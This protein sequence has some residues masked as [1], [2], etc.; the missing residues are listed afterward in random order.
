MPRR[1][2]AHIAR[3]DQ[4]VLLQAPDQPRQRALAQVHGRPRSCMRQLVRRLGRREPLEHLELAEPEAVLALQRLVRARRDRGVAGEHLTPVAT[5][6]G[7]RI[8]GHGGALYRDWQHIA[9]QSLHVH[10]M[11]MHVLYVGMTPLPSPSRHVRRALGP[12]AWA[13]AGAAVRRAVPRRARRLD[14]RR[15]AARRSGADLGLHHLPAAVGRQRLRARLRRPAA[16][17]RPRRRPARPAPRPDRRARR[18][19]RRVAARRPGRRRH[20]ADRR[21]ASSRAPPPRSPRRP[22]C[23]S[24]RPRSPKGPRAT[25]RSAIYTAFGASGFSLRPGLRRPA[26]RAPAG[27]GRSCSPSRSPSLLLAAA[28]A[29][30][31]KD[32][33]SRGPAAPASTSPA[34]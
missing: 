24:S 14:G 1:S 18:L 6:D 22:A 5:S 17:R 10:C 31:A 33:P 21:P 29:L 7:V 32:A 26:D 27:A 12:R 23:R 19:H 34:R 28:P 16:A 30:L 8:G 25:R 4:P 3:C 13:R 20:A 11:H 15:G 2:S 9:S